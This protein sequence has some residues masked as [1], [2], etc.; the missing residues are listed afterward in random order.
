VAAAVALSLIFERRA[1][2]RYV[3][4]VGGFIGLYAQVA[5]VEVRVRDAALCAAHTVKT[6][7]T[8]N[9]AGYGCPWNVFPGS[10][11]ANT[12]CG[13]CLECLRT[14]PYDNVAINLRPIGADLTRAGPRGLDE[15][16]KSVLLLSSGLAYAGV[17]LGPWSQARAAA[18]A[19]GSGGWLLYALSFLVFTAAVIPGLLLA[20]TRIGLGLSRIRLGTTAALRTLSPALIPLGLSVWIAFSLSF[21]LANLS[22]AGPVLSDPLNVGWNLLGTAGIGWA[23]LGQGLFPWMS[24]GILMAGLAW[25]SQRLG[26][27]AEGLRA[28]P[29]LA[30]PLRIVSLG[31]TI[32]VLAALTP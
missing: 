8:G 9:A 18:A 12:F 17:L 25:S 29:R 31:L 13:V 19:V 21:L 1:F 10:L 7:Y 27:I 14:C 22:Y 26:V 28:G 6:C 16:F 4:P 24:V 15:A 32:A 2:C 20:A 3:C 11:K 5:P 23:P 30:W